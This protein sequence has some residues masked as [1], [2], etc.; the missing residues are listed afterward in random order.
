MKKVLTPEE[1]AIKADKRKERREQ[2]KQN[3]PSVIVANIQEEEL[4][5]EEKKLVEKAEKI[6][7]RKEERARRMAI[8]NPQKAAAS[9]TEPK[10]TEKKEPKRYENGEFVPEPKSLSALKSYI[11]TYFRAMKWNSG[12]FVF[13]NSCV[14]IRNFKIKKDRE[15]KVVN[16]TFDALIL[17]PNERLSKTITKD[18]TLENHRSVRSDIVHVFR[19]VRDTQ[20]LTPTQVKDAKS[21]KHLVKH[22]WTAVY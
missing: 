19:E 21:K 13:P 4:T 17:G 6:R 5:P 14:H 9:K 12:D 15:K 3:A 11:T 22:G 7:K 10:P 18:Y 8:Q 16:V 1:K 2:K 20:Y